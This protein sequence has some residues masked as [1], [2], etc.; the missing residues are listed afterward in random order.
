MT[1]GYSEFKDKEYERIL[2]IAEA[3]REEQLKTA[4]KLGISDPMICDDNCP[5]ECSYAW[6]VRLLSEE[7]VA[8]SKRL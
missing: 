6:A 4:I 5:K 7:V 3:R 8:L 1:D 2:R